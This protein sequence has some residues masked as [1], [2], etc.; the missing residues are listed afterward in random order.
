MHQFSGIAVA[1]GLML[2]ISPA[3]ADIIEFFDFAT[4]DA[5][6]DT[7][8]IVDFAE[9]PEF[10]IITDQYEDVGVVLGGPGALVIENPGF[11]PDGHGVRGAGQ[12]DVRLDGP[13]FSFGASFIGEIAFDLYYQGAFVAGPLSVQL[14]DAG[15]FSGVMSD[16]PFDQVII[17]E[18]I[19]PGDPFVGDLYFGPIVPAPG[20]WVVAAG[21]VLLVRGGRRRGGRDAGGRTGLPR[22]A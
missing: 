1:A 13:R 19:T 15:S 14:G 4:W 18:Y 6:V 5:A 20:T 8:S 3:K 7:F 9:Y 11:P 10:T 21:G 16:V 17:Y 2:C 12:I 22:L